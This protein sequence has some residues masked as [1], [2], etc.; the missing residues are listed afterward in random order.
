MWLSIANADLLIYS[1]AK[2]NIEQSFYDGL[3]IEIL[4]FITVQRKMYSHIYKIIIISFKIP[5][6]HSNILIRI[7]KLRDA[8][9]GRRHSA[10]LFTSSG[11]IEPCVGV[12]YFR[13][14]PA[15]LRLTNL[16]QFFTSDTHLF[17]THL[18]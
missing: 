11:Q 1:P 12:Q 9:Q 6:I 18:P 3:E 15:C 7:K 13:L 16:V 5:N 14:R 10:L 2:E 4:Y 8:L 17:E